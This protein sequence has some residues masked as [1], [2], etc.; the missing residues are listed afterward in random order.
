MILWSG[1]DCIDKTKV[2]EWKRSIKLTLIQIGDRD[3]KVTIK[4]GKRNAFQLPQFN[5]VEMIRFT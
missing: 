1:G 2:I 3:N 4:R 5:R